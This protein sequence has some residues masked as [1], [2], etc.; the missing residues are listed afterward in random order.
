MDRA[1]DRDLLAGALGEPQRLPNADELAELLTQA[2]IQLFLRRPDL[3]G[4]LISVGWYLH[5]IASADAALNLYPLPRRRMAFRVAAHIFDLALE[6]LLQEQSASRQ[7]ILRYTFA[8][9]VAYARAELAPNAMAML[10]RIDRVGSSIS[11]I[12]RQEDATTAEDVDEI[13]L[14]I[15]CAILGFD[16][17]RAYS[18]LDQL[19]AQMEQFAGLA[20]GPEGAGPDPLEGTRFALLSPLHAGARGILRYLLR[21]QTT[22]LSTADR[23]LALAVAEERGPEHLDARWAAAHL[24]SIGGELAQASVWNSLPPDTPEGVRRAFVVGR[25]PVLTLWPPQRRMIET[26]EGTSPLDESAR[27]VVLTVPTSAGKTLISQFFV[28]THLARGEG[29]VCYVVPTRSLAREVRRDLSARLRLVTFGRTAPLSEDFD[30]LGSAQSGTVEVMTPERLANLVRDDAN[31]VLSKFSLFIIDEAHSIGSEGRGFTL[32]ST[33]SLLN[34]LTLDSHHRIVL[35]SAALGNS[36]DVV[37]WLAGDQSPAI[38]RHDEW[39]G[40]RRLHGVISS[41][42]QWE[43]QENITRTRAR[44]WVTEERYPTY[45]KVTLRLSASGRTHSLATTEPIGRLSFLKDE[46]GNYKEGRRTREPS[47]STPFEEDLIPVFELLA[48]SGPVLVIRS[49]RRETQRLAEKIAATRE[50]V[51]AAR[52]LVDLLTD[53]LGD[54]HPL[55]VTVGRGVA[56]HN[57]A[58]PGEIQEALEEAVRDGT[59]RYVI[60]T[61]TLTEGVN[62]PVRT[63]VIFDPPPG[64]EWSR[65][66]TPS[67]II[68]AVG[69]AGRA[70]VESEGWALLARN[71]APQPDDFAKLDPSPEDVSTRSQLS[72]ADALSELA[73]FEA[74]VALSSD[75]LFESALDRVSEFISFVWLISTVTEELGRLHL[76]QDLE[77]AL[78]ATLAWRQLDSEQQTRW[79]ALAVQVRSAYID[80]DPEQRRRWARVSMSV[81]SAK[82]LDELSGV[83]ARHA[84]QLD[85]IS[86]SV[87]CLSFLDNI[88]AIE[89][90]CERPE[91]RMPNVYNRQSAPRFAVDFDMV[92]LARDW[93]SGEDVAVI[94]DQH[95]GDVTDITYRLEQVGRVREWIEH[96][97]AWSLSVVVEWANR[98]LVSDGLSDGHLCPEIGAFLRHGVDSRVALDL[99]RSG[100][101][102]RHLA[103]RVAAEFAQYADESDV[104]VRDWIADLGL[105]TLRQRFD[106]TATDLNDLIEII[107]APDRVVGEALA[108]RTAL[109]PIVPSVE[110]S[111]TDSAR[112]E[113]VTEED[114][115]RIAVV[116]G[117]GRQLGLIPIDFQ[118]DVDI[119]L[120]TGVPVIVRVGTGGG[121]AWHVEVELDPSA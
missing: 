67:E 78:H 3:G 109:V 32:E 108:G 76:A 48:Y 40:P 13:A 110:V 17:E 44:K 27:R 75:A 6:Q 51:P 26:E 46:E 7:K 93:I 95:F 97:L 106:A 42:P 61:S 66:L 84:A 91:S 98:S 30:E 22:D 121:T 82:S 72:V 58:L 90:V 71:R 2:E 33:V 24:R 80:S 101:R 92:A 49:T 47:L 10:R 88:G 89:A 83:V 60:A 55:T 119:L 118:A 4:P 102:S 68:N 35:M 39:R 31:A 1:L 87:E 12:D 74:L 28:L 86:D 81:G 114:V 20:S 116:D 45:G 21:G 38:H 19:R 62:L 5:G 117:G 14:A 103:V 37:A 115:E 59:L 36:G 15:G 94:A 70:C 41:E 25:P 11:L 99:L 16:R 34:W 54:Q 57:A 18:L 85:P 113:R 64:S 73:E 56:F 77:E 65:E 53:R 100:M 52:P 79:L 9:Q 50:E 112:L 8:A 43:E 120:T 105:S 29:G 96:Y 107:R 69:R 104:G 111:A 23:A 63:V